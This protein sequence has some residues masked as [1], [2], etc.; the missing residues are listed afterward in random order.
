MGELCS[1]IVMGVIVIAVV[2]EDVD[3]LPPADEVVDTIL[4][5]LW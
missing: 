2:L 3:K 4:D 1:L 5:L